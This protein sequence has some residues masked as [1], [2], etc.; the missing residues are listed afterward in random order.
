MCRLRAVLCL[1]CTTLLGCAAADT[2]AQAAAPA[3]PPQA[4]RVRLAAV[5]YGPIAR[6][7]RVA[8]TLHHK[9]EADLAFKVGGVVQ[10]VNVD[11][12]SRIR[13]GQV[14]AIVDA[15]EVRAIRSQA[16]KSLQKAE[17]DLTRAHQLL[18]S[19]ALGSADVQDSETLRDVALAAATT[20]DFNLRHTTLKAPE[21]GVIDRRNLE[22]GEIVGP[23]QPV[24]HML[25]A[26]RGLV[27]RVELS[28]RDALSIALGQ[29]AR[30]F[31]DAR[32][33][34][35]LRAHV[36]QLATSASVGTGMLAIEVHLDD[37]PATLPS[38]LTAKVEIDSSLEATASVPVS[39]LVDGDADAAALFAVDGDVVRRVPVQLGFLTGDR[40]ALV[41]D[42]GRIQQVVELGAAE[43]SDGERVQIVN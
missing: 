42:L 14:L 25:G 20:A 40:A 23:G 13:R 32:P 33:T 35:P 43:L 2:A 24:F 15:T 39:A 17:R 8:G 3:P 41:S 10:R 30:V 34:R 38:G 37:A 1:L 28:D 21:N 26:A 7:L 16:Q 22:V 36:S 12:G 18:E 31:L 11:A 5:T 29:Q 4:T 19:G 27:V 6:V 9:S